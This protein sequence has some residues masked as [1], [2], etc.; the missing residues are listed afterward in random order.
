MLVGYVA[1]L[2]AAEM[3]EKSLSEV[4]IVVSKLVKGQRR[5]GHFEKSADVTTDLEEETHLTYLWL[6]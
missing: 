4:N 3:E 5:T 1:L 2:N 6:I